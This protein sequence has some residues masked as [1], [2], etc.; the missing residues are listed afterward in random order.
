MSKSEI[1]AKVLELNELWDKTDKSVIAE[2]VERYLYVKYPE[3]AVKWS[4]KVCTI[5]EMT[6]SKSDAVYAWF[7]RSRGNVKIPFLK[8]CSIAVS[9][10][11]DIYKLLSESYPLTDEDM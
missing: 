2:N 4:T 11:V 3:C 5:A 10:D 8:L 7:N 9:L 6:R 1:A